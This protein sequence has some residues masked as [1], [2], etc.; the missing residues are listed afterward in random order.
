[1]IPCGAAAV[2][3][4]CKIAIE[5][6]RASAWSVVMGRIGPVSFIAWNQDLPRVILR[7]VPTQSLV[8]CEVERA[9]LVQRSK[10]IA[11]GD[12]RDLVREHREL[13]AQ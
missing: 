11:L 12:P 13:S 9:L 2:P 3:M 1:M 7:R 10:T 8:P 4:K 5:H 6:D